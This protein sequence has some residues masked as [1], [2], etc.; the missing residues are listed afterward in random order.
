MA[1]ERLATRAR[2]ATHNPEAPTTI[3]T[4]A[5]RGGRTPLMAA[6]ALMTA[7]WTTLTGHDSMPFTAGASQEMVLRA[8]HLRVARLN[9]GPD[10]V[11]IA[12]GTHGRGPF[13]A[14]IAAYSS[15]SCAQ[16]GDLPTL[17]WAFVKAGCSVTLVMEMVGFPSAVPFVLNVRKGG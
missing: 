3:A 1:G 14:G 7:M 2:P 16:L 6:A 13:G 9:D 4:G 5:S 10:S 12:D 8:C 11:L 17:G 15:I